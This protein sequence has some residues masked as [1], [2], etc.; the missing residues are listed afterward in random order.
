[1]ER[2]GS[3]YSLSPTTPANGTASGECYPS[4]ERIGREA[5]IRSKA[6]VHAAL[7]RLVESGLVT[8]VVNAA[9]D[10]RYRADRR[11]NLYRLHRTPVVVDGHV[12]NSDGVPKSGPREDVDNSLRGT[13][14]RTDG[15][16]NIGTQTVIST[17]SKTLRTRGR[18]FGTPRGV[19]DRGERPNETGDPSPR[20]GPRGTLTRRRNRGE[21][22]RSSSGLPGE[23]ADRCSHSAALA[24][25]WATLAPKRL[26]VVPRPDLC[27]ECGGA[28]IA[29][30]CR[31]EP[32]SLDCPS[33]SGDTVTPR[34]DRDSRGRN[35]RAT[36]RRLD[37]RILDLD[38]RADAARAERREARRAL[39]ELGVSWAALAALSDCSTTAIH[40]DLQS[41]EARRRMYAAENNGRRISS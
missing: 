31:L 28:L 20:A 16:P 27:S 21:H 4:I 5:G 37:R 24:R 8:R 38:S 1:M 35:S 41:D 17:V 15:V 32:A 3:S 11:P 25:H 40:R 12:D 7:S 2:T 29:G 39:R 34:G 30:M 6:T 9:P 22:P 18:A 14:P 23:V 36:V 13:N 33:V 26:R 19:R 10:S